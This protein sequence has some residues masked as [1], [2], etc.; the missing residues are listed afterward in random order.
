MSDAPEYAAPARRSDVAGLAATWIGVGDL[1]VFYD[2][3]V[4][5]AERLAAAGV[6][7]E[8]VAVQGM[9]HTAE[10]IRQEAPSMKRFHAGI[11]EH[12][13]RHLTPNS[14]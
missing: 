4:G 9:Y 7:C 2:E 11:V 13:R 14:A 12:L 3:N 6:P 5:Y 10:G 1:E 8:L